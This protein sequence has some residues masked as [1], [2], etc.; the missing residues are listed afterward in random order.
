M[1]NTSSKDMNSGLL[2]KVFNSRQMSC[3]VANNSRL[4]ERGQ[5]KKQAHQ[6]M[7]I[8]FKDALLEACRD[9]MWYT[10]KAR[11]LEVHDLH[12]AES[13]YHHTYYI[14]I[15]EANTWAAS[16]KSQNQNISRGC[17]LPGRKR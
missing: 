14:N 5:D 15:Q 17:K 16:W 2:G 7:T 8:K 9:C 10:V 4:E 3:F 12:L 13:V 11:V 1:P 6:A